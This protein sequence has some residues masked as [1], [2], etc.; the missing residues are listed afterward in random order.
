MQSFLVWV[1]KGCF[2]I[3]NDM[4]VHGVWNN[5]EGVGAGDSTINASFKGV[6]ENDLI[7]NAMAAEGCR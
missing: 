7:G 1:P 4:L 6:N 3:F 5:Y 2:M